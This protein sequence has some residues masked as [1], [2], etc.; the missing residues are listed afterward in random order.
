MP[1]RLLTLLLLCASVLAACGGRD[2]IGPGQ[3]ESRDVQLLRENGGTP[4]ISG[5]LVNLT[6]ATI[7]SVQVQVYFYDA[8]NTRVDEM[9]FPVRDLEPNVEVAFRE[10]IDSDADIQRASIAAILRL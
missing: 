5:K 1:L 2:P 10:A 9:V 7:P 4:Y 8:E 6:D 3:V